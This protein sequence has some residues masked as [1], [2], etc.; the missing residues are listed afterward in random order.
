MHSPGTLLPG[1]DLPIDEL[2]HDG[3]TTE[4]DLTAE[5]AD[6]TQ[7]DPTTKTIAQQRE[8]TRKV[9]AIALLV[10]LGLVVVGWTLTSLWA[11]SGDVVVVTDT[12]RTVF[13][14]MLGL[15]GTVVGFYFGGGGPSDAE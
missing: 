14:G 10:G 4:L 1:T 13:T 8:D 2:A 11:D 5:S 15:T 3:V 7:F 9:M 12:F 6:T